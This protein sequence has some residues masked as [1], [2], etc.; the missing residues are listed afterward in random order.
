MQ[1]QRLGQ[2]RHGI[3]GATQRLDARPAGCADGVTARRARK[4]TGLDQAQFGKGIERLGRPYAA[5]VPGLDQA[6]GLLKYR[7]SLAQPPLSQ[8]T[9]PQDA[10]GAGLHA[11]GRDLD[12][13][14][15]DC[16]WV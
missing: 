5:Q 3:P 7:C 15:A 1:T 10:P 12:T 8:T 11:K 2:P 6:A 4:A 9:L 16:R 14:V 13:H